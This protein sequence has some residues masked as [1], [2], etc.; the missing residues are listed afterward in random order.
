M[1]LPKA[2]NLMR[3]GVFLLAMLLALAPD[4]GAGI[5]LPVIQS[6]APDTLPA[7]PTVAVHYSGADGLELAVD[8]TGLEFDLMET[9]GGVFLA[10]TCPNSPL[11]GAV[12]TPALP[13]IRRLFVAPI[14]ATVE[15][16]YQTG[17]P[18]DID[19]VSS[20]YSAPILPVQPPIV[21]T[22]DT[23]A[24]L[25]FHFDDTAYALDVTRPAAERVTVT[26]LGMVRHQRLFMLEVRPL[27]Y[28][29]ARATL[30]VWPHIDISIN[31][32]GNNPGVT[33]EIMPALRGA[34]LNPPPAEPARGTEGNYLIVVPD[35]YAAGIAA[36]AT[37]KEAMGFSVITHSVSPGTTNT[38]IKNYIQSL[39]GTVDEPDYLLLVGDSDTIPAWTGGGARLAS[40]D[41]P[42]VC[43]DGPDDW[44]PDIA[45][46]RFSVRSQAELQAIVTKSLYL[47]A[48]EFSDPDFV[49]RAAFLLTDDETSGGEDTQEWVVSTYMDPNDFLSYKIYA[50]EGGDTQDVTDALNTGCLHVVYFGHSHITS[51]WNPAFNPPDI[52]NLTNLDKYCVILG[53]SCNTNN[54]AN[55]DECLGETWIRVSEKGAAAFL[56]ASTQIYYW[57]PPWNEASFLE[58]HYFESFFNEN[59]WELSPAWQAALYD[60]LA[61]YGP[62]APATRDYFEMYI[63]LGD[64]ALHL[65]GTGFSISADPPAQ[66]LCC[67]P[68]TQAEYTLD[69][70][71]HADFSDV[72]TLSAAGNPLGSSVQFSTN[73]QAPPFTSVM[74]I[75]DIPVGASPDEYVI[76][77]TGTATGGLERMVPLVLNLA[78][79]AAG[80][81]TLTSPSNGEIEVAKNPTLTWQPAAQAAQYELEVATDA[82][83]STIVY[84]AIETET[85]HQIGMNLQT[86]TEH[87][88]HVRALNGCGDGDFCPAFSFRTIYQPDYFTE[89]F[90]VGYDFDLDYMSLTIVPDGTI[91][92]YEVCGDPITELPTDPT[93]G[94]PLNLS[95]DSYE[96]V[97][98]MQEVSLYGT[99]YA[100]FYVNSNG[101][102]TFI[103][104][105]NNPDET[106]TRHF[107]APRVSGVYDDLDPSSGGAVSYVET[108][109]R[110]AVTFLDVPEYETTNTNTFQIEL[111]FDGTIR[112]S[113]LN[114]DS[115]DSMVGLSEGIGVPADFLDSDLSEVDSCFAPNTAVCCHGYVCHDVDPTDPQAPYNEDDCLA[116]GGTYILD[117]DC[118]ADPCDCG[119]VDYRA[120]S[121]C[122]DDGINSYD[123]DHF[124]QAVGL[125]ADWMNSH[126][127]NYFCANDIN[128][129]GV[130]NSYDIDWFIN[131][132]SNGYADPCP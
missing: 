7:A 22:P 21:V 83:F 115:V 99:S 9:R 109:D 121:N 3:G 119:G 32:L 126:S 62:E 59:I 107:S 19:L 10:V 75:S 40:T 43:M 2:R 51:W 24:Q 68:V 80:D 39:W 15:L 72:V 29:P 94:T 125:P 26:E 123:I 73:S 90:L 20:G 79:T 52:N 103:D 4:A 120:D 78:T 55:H 33:P 112:L 128:C 23:P 8:L 41:L 48:G 57:P 61:F 104:G 65:P 66:H 77:V 71:P 38:Q 18:V 14:G 116:A 81:V 88:W 1:L 91:D 28:N 11:D 106:P 93:G 84:S 17:E 111:F 45:L 63:L 132:V 74:T 97:F 27:A 114:V 92:Y 16:R 98:P 49:K 95:D 67:P 105:D 30:T 113:W 34:L 6:G 89:E 36:F 50:T 35:E 54:F 69:I 118:A 5:W 129:D 85:S 87:F 102:L 46:G 76:E 86:D 44:Y 101:H 42:Y 117:T 60:L 25:P 127:C 100:W 13:M 82:G 124:I 110:V 70:Q 96:Y 131:A 12:G 47:E 64:P 37:A 56:A 130:V 53:M 31:F 58:K 122:M 108:G